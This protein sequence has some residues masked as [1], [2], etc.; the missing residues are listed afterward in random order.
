MSRLPLSPSQP[1]LAAALKNF[2]KDVLLNL[3]R[4]VCCFPSSR[5]YK[6]GNL[7]PVT[8]G[9]FQEGLKKQE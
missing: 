9:E 3:S 4:Q 8:W 5:P 6:I 1:R 7:L 2:P